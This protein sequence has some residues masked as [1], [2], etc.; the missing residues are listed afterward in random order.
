M[1]AGTPKG[2]M[3]PHL[4]FI[5]SPLEASHREQREG[6]RVINTESLSLSHFLSSRYY[7]H[8]HVRCSAALISNGE[9]LTHLPIEYHGSLLFYRASL[10]YQANNLFSVN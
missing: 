6:D 7:L 4:P 9:L 5:S 2:R 10:G 3:K 1:T 8:R